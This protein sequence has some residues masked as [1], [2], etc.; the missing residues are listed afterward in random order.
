[1]Y[2]GKIILSFGNIILDWKYGKDIGNINRILETY[3][4]DWKHTD[5]GN[6]SQYMID[7]QKL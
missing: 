4:L 1:M 3:E 6:I 5:I 2:I 7:I